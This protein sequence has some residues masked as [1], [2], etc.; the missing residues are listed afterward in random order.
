MYLAGRSFD[1][2]YLKNIKSQA[3]WSYVAFKGVLPHDQ[4]IRLYDESSV[5]LA[6]ESYDNPN[7]GY[8]MG[9]LGCTKIPDYMASGLPVVVSDSIVWGA[10][11]REYNCGGVVKD[12][13]NK[14]EIAHAIKTILD[15]PKRAKEMGE[16]AL[17]ASHEEFNWD[18]QEKVLFEMYSKLL[19]E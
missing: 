10:I 8:K 4:V 16:N 19:N 15:N 12:P 2:E 6:I 11:I 7:G 9:S 14:N 5:G 17:K 18:T 1:E 13:N 3:G